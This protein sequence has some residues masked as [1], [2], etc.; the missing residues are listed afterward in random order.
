MRRHVSSKRRSKRSART[1]VARRKIRGGGG[2]SFHVMIVTAGRPSLI[3]MIDS[4][5][6]QLT[7][8]DALTVV[9]DGKFAKKRST[10][11][12]SWVDTIKCK[13]T[14][15]EQI[16]GLK[17]YGHHTIN[18]YLPSLEPK[19]TY[20]MFADDDDV[21][22]NGAFDALRSKCVDPDILY[23]A[24][25]KDQRG[26]IVPPAGLTTIQRGMIG[27]VCGIIPFDKRSEASMGTKD[28]MG[29]FNY[30]N[31]LQNKV[32]GLHFLD[33]VIYLCDSSVPDAANGNI[34][35]AKDAG[36]K[37]KRVFLSKENDYP[38]YK[39]YLESISDGNEIRQWS[40]SSTFEGNTYYMCIGRV[41][42]EK[43]PPSCRIGFINTEQL[44]DP[45][46]LEEYNRTV[47]HA[48]DIFDYSE[49]NIRITGKG[50]YLPYK[51]NPAETE[52]LKSFMNVPKEYDV[53]IVICNFKENPCPDTSKRR[54][55]ATKTLMASGVS[56]NMIEGW[57]DARDRE[58]GKCRIL[59]NI[60]FSDTYKIY[61]AIRCERWRFAGMP[62]ISETSARPMPSGIIESSYEDLAA[63]VKREL[64]KMKSH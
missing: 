51:K 11:D 38:F 45:V 44:S 28:H 1:R 63:T 5:K 10:Y 17:H 32:K 53:A 25:F 50:S 12:P 20:V 42:Y 8:K 35:I 4:L 29:D 59:I 15:K 18:K 46:K 60:H 34:K 2:P 13:V 58:I 9:F 21:Y 3:K 57:D 64:S 23:I 47:K 62:I 52:K 14:I 61:E 24:R 19:T 30:Y 39:E 27:K 36:S 7:E 41:P 55:D 33:D 26:T 31:D 16:P 37:V 48:I 22:V 56:V 49:D 54:I 6:G 40:D 43:I